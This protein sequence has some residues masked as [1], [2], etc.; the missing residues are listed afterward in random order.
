MATTLFGMDRA[1]FK[2]VCILDKHGHD[3]VLIRMK[4]FNK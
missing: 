2:N 3:F 4:V 1:Y